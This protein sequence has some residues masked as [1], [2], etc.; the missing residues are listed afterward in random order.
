[1]DTLDKI[2]LAG[3]VEKPRTGKVRVPASQRRQLITRHDDAVMRQL[4]Q[5]ALDND[6]TVQGLVAE[7]LN[8]V[9]LKYQKSPI[10]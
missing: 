8:M 7:A 9:F 3:G 4:R 5:L 1:M 10:A 6:T 2:R